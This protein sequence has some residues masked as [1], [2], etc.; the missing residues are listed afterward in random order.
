MEEKTL[1]TITVSCENV[2]GLLNQITIIFT[3]RATNIETLFGF[4]DAVEGVHKIVITTISDKDSIEKIV[5][6]IEKRI[7][8]IEVSYHQPGQGQ[9]EWSPQQLGG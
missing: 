6:Q 9:A 8:I 3:R 7:G 2:R 1:Y 4:P 5:R